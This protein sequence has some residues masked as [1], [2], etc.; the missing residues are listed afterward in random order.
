M[1]KIAFIYPGQGAQYVGMGKDIAERFPSAQKIFKTASMALRQDVEQ[2]VFAGDGE[3]LALTENTQ[4]ALLTTCIASTQPLLEKGI[5]PDISAGL[6][7]GEYA[8]HI[9]ADTFSFEDA[10][11][12]VRLRGKYMQ[13]E[14]PPGEGGMAA[15]LGLDSEFVEDICQ[16]VTDSCAT[17]L[18]EPVN[19]NCPGQLVIA[20]DSEA[21]AQACELCK[22][23]G[24]KKVVPLAVSAP[25]H[26]S[27][28]RGAGD[29]LEKALSGITYHDMSIP[30]VSNVNA[31]A[32]ND[33]GQVARLLIEQVYSPVRW[34]Q[35]VKTMIR[36]GVDIFVE[37]GPGK[38]LAGFIRKIAK[39]V[40]T[41]S[42]SDVESL[43]NA[44]SFFKS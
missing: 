23:N 3:E 15:I 33:S 43:E 1:G 9:I 6:S 31:K 24:A 4:P 10:V 38:T 34:E 29:K 17:F 12:I 11:R 35:C 7:I 40:T 2:L 42:V 16:R 26:S 18:V 22:E 21:V 27:L 30:V 32:I 5:K 36:F 14:V 37:I 39:D 19:Y 28:L 44:C 20:G 41:L 8:A 13:E 25:F